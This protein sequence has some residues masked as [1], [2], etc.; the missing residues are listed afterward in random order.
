MTDGG[1]LATNL[2]TSRHNSKLLK[3]NSPDARTLAILNGFTVIEMSPIYIFS[4]MA[5]YPEGVI[6]IISSI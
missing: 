5:N 4:P 2:M 3:K 6:R 1:S